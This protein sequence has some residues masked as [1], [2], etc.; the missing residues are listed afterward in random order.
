MCWSGTLPCVGWRDQSPLL[1]SSG[2]AAS[3][4]RRSDLEG[5]RWGEAK[6]NGPP[7]PLVSRV[8][9][10]RTPSPGRPRERLPK[11]RFV[12]LLEQRGEAVP[13]SVSHLFLHFL[14]YGTCD[15][16]GN[17][18]RG[19]WRTQAERK[20]K[21]NTRQGK[22]HA[23]QQKQKICMHTNRRRF[24]SVLCK[25]ARGIHFKE[26]PSVTRI[27]ALMFLKRRCLFITAFP[28][29]MAASW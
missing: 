7:P 17:R 16:G 12:V 23:T 15:I 10:C 21:N 26:Y 19:S 3:H 18:A 13:L 6:Q 8:M 27:S 29:P 11:R 22:Q 4:A 2:A 28:S 14:L 1:Q 25:D 20:H 24:D 5:T 9:A